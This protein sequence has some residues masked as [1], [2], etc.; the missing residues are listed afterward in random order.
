MQWIYRGGRPWSYARRSTYER[1][2][3]SLFLVVMRGAAC[4]PGVAID[5]S[6]TVARKTSD[7]SDFLWPPLGNLVALF[8]PFFFVLCCGFFR[9][10]ISRPP[11]TS[12]FVC[13]LGR[14]S[15]WSV[16]GDSYRIF[17]DRLW[18]VR[19]YFGILIV[20]IEIIGMIHI[21]INWITI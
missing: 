12:F 17:V 14:T 2:N 9:L 8:P 19:N 6:S 4:K 10:K 18:I 15:V 20:E 1:H 16:N 3:V 21:V 13:T 11:F 7:P 5:F